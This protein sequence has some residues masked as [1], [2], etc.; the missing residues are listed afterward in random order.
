MGRSRNNKL[1]NFMASQN[2]VGRTVQV[3]IAAASGNSLV[4]E[5]TV[6]RGAA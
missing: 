5:L 1:V 2:L 6:A 4:G 3:R